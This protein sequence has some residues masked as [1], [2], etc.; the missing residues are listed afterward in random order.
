MALITLTY[1]I[2]YCYQFPL[3]LWKMCILVLLVSFCFCFCFCCCFF[4]FVLLFFL[5]LIIYRLFLFPNFPYLFWLGKLLCYNPHKIFSGASNSCH[6][7]A[8]SAVFIYV[9]LLLRTLL[10]FTFI[11]SFKKLKLYKR[12][13]VDC[14]HCN[15]TELL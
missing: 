8:Y 12:L 9:Q 2:S 6:M 7:F 1:T 4:C 11:Q 10:L 13:F 14:F 3:Y 15:V 5:E